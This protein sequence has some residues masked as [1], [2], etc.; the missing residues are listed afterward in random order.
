MLEGGKA[1]ERRYHFFPPLCAPSEWTPGRE[2][3][4]AGRE[5]AGRHLIRLV[6][7][8]LVPNRQW[9]QEWTKTGGHQIR[10]NVWN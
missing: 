4:K 2:S 10:A 8:Y 5:G 3:V 1:G 9:S 6:P 7:G